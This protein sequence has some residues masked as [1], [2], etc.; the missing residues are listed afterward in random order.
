MDRILPADPE[1]QYR[2]DYTNCHI[3]TDLEGSE[4]NSRRSSTISEQGQGQ[5]QG[6]GQPEFK[7]TPDSWSESYEGE[8]VGLSM[9]DCDPSSFIFPQV[10]IFLI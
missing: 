4:V 3:D 9:L 5:G 6:Q 8:D 1:A 2:L 7:V 10:E